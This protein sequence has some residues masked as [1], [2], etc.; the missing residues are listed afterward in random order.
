[1]AAKQALGRGL[2]A[3]LGD[4][5]EP[6]G[7]VQ[8]VDVYAIDTNISQPRKAFD[9]DKLKEL[10]ESIKRHGVVQPILVRANGERY[11][12]I[13]GERRFRAARIAGLGEVPVVVKDMDDAEVME[14]ALIENLQREDLNPVEEAAAIRFLMQQH[15][16]TQEE[17]SRRL[18]KSRPVIANT[19]RLLSLPEDVQQL[20]REGKLQAGQARALAGL[21]SAEKQ[22]ALA[23]KIVNE[24]LSARA[25]EELA[26]QENAEKPA[27]KQPAPPK[28][29]DTDLLAAQETLREA[30]GTKVSIQGSPKRGKIII[31]YYSAEDLQGIYDML[32]AQR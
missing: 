29:A 17:V 30:L 15:D 8:N 32:A 20:L 9:E 7:G 19:L 16:L 6:V 28:P 10:A 18:S 13:A 3:L 21:Q 25:A 12:I 14:V 1:M 2:D 23:G 22:S 26:R 27:K 5:A 31:E 24:G 11:T 4:Y